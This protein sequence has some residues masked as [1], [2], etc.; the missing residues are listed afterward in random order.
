MAP[1]SEALTVN[2]NNLKNYSEELKK[3]SLT[4]ECLNPKLVSLESKVT[5]L[6]DKIE[7]LTKSKCYTNS[8]EDEK[9]IPNTASPHIT[10]A[11]KVTHSQPQPFLKLIEDAVKPYLKLAVK[12][13]LQLISRKKK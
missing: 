8:N 12:Q 3:N 11:P 6:T 5:E 7:V 1:K 4:M 2:L 10:Q 9:L 13:F